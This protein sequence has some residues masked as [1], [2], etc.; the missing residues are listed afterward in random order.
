MPL[1]PTPRSPSPNLY[2][3]SSTHPLPQSQGGVNTKSI[4]SKEV[5]IFRERLQPGWTPVGHLGSLN[6]GGLF[7]KPF[8]YHC[9]VSSSRDSHQRGF[10][11]RGTEK[12]SVE[13]K[14][15]AEVPFSQAGRMSDNLPSVVAI[16]SL[17]SR[18]SSLCVA[19]WRPGMLEVIW[20]E[21]CSH[22]F[23]GLED[24][25]GPRLFWTTEVG[26]G[27]VLS[28][29]AS[30]NLVLRCGSVLASYS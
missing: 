7:W 11:D 30:C 22:G 13:R 19:S 3:T 20:K 8:H 17:S 26:L 27:K 2:L 28:F 23:P 16:S 29:R 12:R 5:A 25:L 10:D 4:L 15:W 21:C 1:L 18:T 6:V 24:G 9:S 14:S